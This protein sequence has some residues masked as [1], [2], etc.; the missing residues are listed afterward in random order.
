MADAS[1]TPKATA[2]RTQREPAASSDCGVV[3]DVASERT[4]AALGGGSDGL[5]GAEGTQEGP[6]RHPK[7]GKRLSTDEQRAEDKLAEIHARLRDERRT[8]LPA[9]L[10]EAELLAAYGCSREDRDAS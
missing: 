9:G 2:R 7:T 10:T 6:K 8:R 4:I 1:S 5:D 3:S